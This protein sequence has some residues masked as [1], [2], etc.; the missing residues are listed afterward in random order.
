MKYSLGLDLGIASLGWAVMKLDNENNFE[1][2]DDVG[3]RIFESLENPKDGKRLVEK[4][5]EQRGQRR[6][7]RRRVQRISKTNSKKR[8]ST[9]A[10]FD[11]FRTQACFWRNR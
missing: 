3:V 4:R 11:R 1:R 10:N 5:R 7:K 9:C 8:K 6:I 2:I